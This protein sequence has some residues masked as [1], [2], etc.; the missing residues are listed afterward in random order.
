MEM[1]STIKELAIALSKAQAEMPA[2]PFNAVNPFLK[3]QYADLGS[4]VETARPVLAKYGIAVSQHPVS[5]GD[6]LGLTTILMHSSGEWMESTIYLAMGEEKGKSNAQVAG[7]IIS[8]LRRYSLA[9]I[10]GM[11]ADQDTDA[12]QPAKPAQKATPSNGNINPL[13]AA[14]DAPPTDKAMAEWAEL[15][16]QAEAKGISVPPLPENVTT[17]QLRGIYGEVRDQLKQKA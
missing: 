14:A 12:N 9:A 2:A 16:A 8:Y 1:S 11:Y 15:L 17:A 4:I 13:K 3:N 6:C 10:L 7:S 5:D